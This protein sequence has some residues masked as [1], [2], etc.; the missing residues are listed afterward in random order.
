MPTEITQP[1]TT[2]KS[3]VID[4][5]IA[6]IKEYE[7]GSIPLSNTVTFSQPGMVNTIKTHQN[8]GFLK[9]LPEG[10]VDDRM[11]YDIVTPLVDTGVKNTDIDTKNVEPTSLTRDYQSHA[12][13]IK[14]ELQLFFKYTDED[15]R[16]N[17]F[18]EIF[19]DEGNAVARKVKE[20]IYKKVLL[21]NLYV[22]DQTAETLE[23]TTVIERDFMDQTKLR[24]MTEWNADE[25]NNLINSFKKSETSTKSPY[26]ELFYC[27]S[28][29][30]KDEL[31]EINGIESSD[32][33]DDNKYVQSMVVFGRAKTTKKNDKISSEKGFILFAEELKPEEIKITRNYIIKKYKPYEEAHFGAYKGRWMREGYRELCIQN[34]NRAN[35][36]GNQIRIGMKLSLKHILWSSDDTIKGRN[37]LS[38]LQDGQILQAKDLQLLNLS[39]NKNLAAY[40][41]EWNQNIQNAREK[42]R[43]FEMALSENSPS[44]TTATEANINNINNS[45]YFKFK[46]QKLGIF[47]RNI[48]NRWVLPE[49]LKNVTD[50]HEIEITGDPSYMDLIYDALVNNWYLQN[51]LKMPTHGPEQAD[52]IKQ[53]KKE[54]LMKN[55]KEFLTIQKDF[56]K[57]AEIVLDVTVTDESSNKQTKTTN[58]LNLVKYTSNPIIMQ[59]PTSRDIIIE[60]ANDLGF[61]VKKT[62]PPQMPMQPGQMPNNQPGQPAGIPQETA[63]NNQNV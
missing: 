58:G 63:N 7:S 41:Q 28:E 44:S 18:V 19:I 26:F 25:V 57:N 35:E 46:Q 9:S 60:I 39:E 38:S 49:L 56:F 37:I 11:S 12:L 34:Q 8:H 54:E 30:S 42:C 27:F 43:A 61:K 17:N 55:R 50:E 62:A 52:M 22:I 47:F 14:P 45:K 40:A 33:Q 3:R 13:L 15:T 16:I 10:M 6:Y 53:M 36:L 1:T 23:D 59:D 51:L 24:R 21:E 31:N 20:G 48:Y 2:A 5:I 4:R 32:K 29:I